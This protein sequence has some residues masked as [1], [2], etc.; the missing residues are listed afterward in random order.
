MDA[1]ERK[2]DVPPP[3]G[4]VAASS[5]P[6]AARPRTR[7]PSLRPLDE[8]LP[9]DLRAER[10][11]AAIELMQSLAPPSVKTT[12]T[13]T[14]RLDRDVKRWREDAG[15]VSDILLRREHDERE[16]RAAAAARMGDPLSTTP[17]RPT[18]DRPVS[19]STSHRSAKPRDVAWVRAYRPESVGQVFDEAAAA[20]RAAK[21]AAAKAAREA[22]RAAGCDRG[23]GDTSAAAAAAA[24]EGRPRASAWRRAFAAV[25][26]L[27]GA[28]TRAE[29]LAE[30]EAAAAEARRRRAARDARRDGT[31]DANLALADELREMDA[32][33]SFRIRSSAAEFR[34]APGATIV[35]PFG[36]ASASSAS[37]SSASARARA[38][39]LLGGSAS[40]PASPTRRGLLPRAP[41]PSSSSRTLA[42]RL[43]VVERGAAEVRV[44]A[45]P[46]RL[47]HETR[48]AAGGDPRE[49]SRLVATLARGHLFGDAVVMS[50]LYALP[51]GAF[52]VA[53]DDDGDGSAVSNAPRSNATSSAT[54]PRS[55]AT[56]SATPPRS[57]ATSSATARVVSEDR[58]GLVA[59][60]LPA[61]AYDAMAPSLMRRRDAFESALRAVPILSDR[62]LSR[63][64]RAF[65]GDAMRRESWN[66]GQS[67]AR[68]GWDGSCLFVIES[69][70]A[71]A[72]ARR[73]SQNVRGLGNFAPGAFFG[74]L[75]LARD[76]KRAATVTARDV[77]RTLSLDGA[78]FRA[79]LRG[80]PCPEGDA[81]ALTLAD[82]RA[83]ELRALRVR[84]EA[85]FRE[86]DPGVAA[87]ARAE[88]DDVETTGSDQDPNRDRNVDVAARARS[89][90][91]L[92]PAPT[93]TD[94][95]DDDAA[96]V[97][98]SGEAGTDA[99]E[100]AA[101][102]RV[103]GKPP[104]PDV[105][106]RL[107]NALLRTAP[108]VSVGRPATSDAA[109]AADRA[110]A[111]R[112]VAGETWAIRG[113]P[114]F[115]AAIV[116]EGRLHVLGGEHVG[117]FAREH[118]HVVDDEDEEAT[119]PAAAAAAADA[120][121]LDHRAPGADAP[122]K[123]LET[124][125]PGDCVGVGALLHP[126]SRWEVRVVAA[127]PTTVWE[128]TADDFESV[129]GA[130][131]D[132]KRDRFAATIDACATFRALTRTQKLRVADALAEV[133][134]APGE[135]VFHQGALAPVGKEAEVDA[136]VDAE[137]E[138]D[139]AARRASPDGVFVVEKGAAVAS[140]VAPGSR[141]S[142]VIRAYRRGDVFGAGSVLDGS[143]R[144][145]TVTAAEAGGG[146]RDAP[147]WA[148]VSFAV[149]TPAALDQLGFL[150]AVLARARGCE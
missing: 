147:G 64:Q 34:A 71:I 47:A 124:A 111:R 91:A 87:R 29:R 109:A 129:A 95:W 10:T 142:E 144:A 117:D 138:R 4:D 22:R 17:R 67:I 145:R 88:T 108:F 94:G 130:V 73:R 43:Y 80:A 50:Q 63:A 70:R 148:R 3:R 44:A 121:A 116:D 54:A 97:D 13:G 135:T 24:R 16:A 131:V 115:A 82:A 112:L 90:R 58:G 48:V 139:D 110:R 69:G 8:M 102:R 72:H 52:V 89:G 33:E 132:D 37:A 56:S 1:H 126:G 11:R 106:R 83:A 75:A 119:D 31:F 19:P 77:T 133:T 125:R 78:A 104:D 53:V 41:S 38:N 36:D 74:E 2:E 114:A 49:G 25:R 40:V 57:N 85:R 26:R 61:S 128:L 113:T 76:V 65:L 98:G 86:R 46:S 100:D 12:G 60:T 62:I 81:L 35:A 42:P 45:D 137:V 136:E 96:G 51:R 134:F 68:Q 28:A 6:T 79:T 118:L 120:A 105:K 27:T 5:V 32:R 59:W 99:A 21:R 107:V 84:D 122:A 30:E 9:E 23:R 150:R 55:N 14:T 146:A 93:P 143:R 123:L 141:R 103:I 66:V 18:D 15:K 7:P 149:I 127:A 101:R 92:A 20:E 39:P 140:A